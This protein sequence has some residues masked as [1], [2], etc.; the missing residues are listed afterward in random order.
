MQFLIV[1]MKNLM[2]RKIRSVLTVVGIGVGVGAVVSLVTIAQ[3]F[4]AMWEE[5]SAQRGIDL[6]VVQSSEAAST[7]FS[8][9]DQ[10]LQPELQGIPGIKSARGVLLDIVTIDDRPFVP[11][12]GMEM[13]AFDDAFLQANYTLIE[14]RMIELG[15]DEILMGKVLAQNLNLKAGDDVDIEADILKIVGIFES[16][17]FYQDGI[18]IVE[19]TRLQELMTRENQV[20]AFEVQ[21]EDRT[22]TAIASMKEKIPATIPSITAMDG[23]EAGEQDFGIRLARAMSWG[24]SFIALLV[25]VIGTMN[26][27][28]MSVFERTREIGILRALGWRSSRVLKMILG[29]SLVLSFLGG[30]FG[31]IFGVLA[32]KAVTL[33]P[34][35]QA[36]IYGKYRVEIFLEGMAIALSLGM[37]GGFYPAYRASKLSPLEA[38]RYE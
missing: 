11:V 13:N 16:G 37:V 19:L 23:R 8:S 21:L 17:T 15:K 25:G 3:G 4:V 14:G 36:F 18:V 12:Y 20:N 35:I 28:F 31:C 30:I 26:T 24:V 29:E 27:M 2:R 6:I 1:L 9:I 34:D 10:S 22:A 33:V 5:G 7:F 32:V 38:I